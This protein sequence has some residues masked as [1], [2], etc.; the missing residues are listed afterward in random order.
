MTKTTR[1]RLLELHA[2]HPELNQTQIAEELGVTRQRVSALV[3]QLQLNVQSGPVG[4]GGRRTRE[5]APAV[6]AIVAP[7]TIGPSG[8]VLLAAADLDRRG[9][10]VFFP[11]NPARARCDLVAID[12][13]DRVEQ[14]VVEKRAKRGPVRYDTPENDRKIRRA[15]ILTDQPVQYSPA[16]RPKNDGE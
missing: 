11:L 13:R 9:Y 8:A 16:L 6:D 15:M 7:R 10:D 5:A 1:E 3:K 14:I 4:I 12:E 2:A